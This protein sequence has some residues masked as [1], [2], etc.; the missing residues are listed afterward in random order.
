[1]TDELYDELREKIEALESENQAIRAWQENVTKLMSQMLGTVENQK[2]E[3]K[4]T[5]QYAYINRIRVESLPYELRDPDYVSQVF[6]PKVMS[7]SETR[8]EVIDNNK[9]ISRFGDGEF[10]IIAGIGR[11]NFQAASEELAIK[12]KKVL[13][14]DDAGIVIGLNRSFYGNLE[15]LS[16]VDADGVRAYMRPDVR[17]LHASLL[18]RTKTYGNT[19]MNS[20]SD[21]EDASELKRLWDKKDCVFIEGRHTGMGVGNDLFDNCSNIERIICPA[22]NAIEKYDDIMEAA[23]KQ[24]RN[25][26]VLIAL[27]PTATALSYDLYKEGYHAVDIGHIDLC[28]ERVLRNLPNLEDVSISYKYCNWDEVGE[29]RQIED[30]D[31]PVYKSQIVDVV[32]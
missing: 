16:E 5:Q 30:I 17:K 7:I 31:D 21:I 23:L 20:I 13:Q 27:G 26:L 24:P 28:Y 14:S 25:K 10:G 9:S 1:M 2:E 19:V 12:L 22:E 32:Y 8:K 15:D 11:W 4:K 3:L 6:V 29:R 18:S